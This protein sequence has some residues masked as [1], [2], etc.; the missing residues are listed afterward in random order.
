[1]D[2]DYNDIVTW[3]WRRWA[4]SCHI[5]SLWL[6]ICGVVGVLWLKLKGGDLSGLRNLYDLRLLRWRNHFRGKWF[7]FRCKLI[8]L[9]TKV[10]SVARWCWS[11]S[12]NN[13]VSSP[14]PLF[15]HQRATVLHGGFP[16][17][18]LKIFIDRFSFHLLFGSQ[19]ISEVELRA[20][21]L[22]RWK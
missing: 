5:W 21:W 18:T 20:C 8:H 15:V 19:L 13:Q 17:K 9:I 16:G 1:M 4:F 7:Q 14:D 10:L 6:E 2:I 11:F 12:E 22:A 3:W